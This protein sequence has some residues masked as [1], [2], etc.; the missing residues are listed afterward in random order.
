MKEGLLLDC[1]LHLYPKFYSHVILYSSLKTLGTL[2]CVQNF[3][4]CLSLF[5]M[6]INISHKI[7]WIAYQ[8]IQIYIQ[9]WETSL[10]LQNTF[11]VFKNCTQFMNIAN[12]RPYLHIHQYINVC[13]ELLAFSLKLP[14]CAQNYS[15]H[16][17]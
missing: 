4:I 5:G 3:Q 9:V 16:L 11:Y 17:Y 8:I 2:C 13:F 1:K 15:S 14:C 7:Y 12:I 6:Y 10:K